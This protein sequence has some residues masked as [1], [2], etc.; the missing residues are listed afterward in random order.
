MFFH[1]QFFHIHSSFLK[2][3]IFPTESAFLCFIECLCVGFLSFV[4]FYI[5]YFFLSIVLCS[6]DISSA[7]HILMSSAH[8]RLF[9]VSNALMQTIIFHSIYYFISYYLICRYFLKIIFLAHRF[10]SFTNFIVM[11][12]AVE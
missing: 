11:V 8:V 7:Q 9:F 12:S 4:L 1:M 5:M 10:I 2:L 6:S 3:C